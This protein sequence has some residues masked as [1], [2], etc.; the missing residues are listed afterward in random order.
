M[1][2]SDIV[3]D[4]LVESYENLDRLDRDL[5]GLEKN[6]QD[7]EALAG[8]FRTI[9]TIKGTCGF[10]GFN[11]LEKVAHVGENLL[12]RLR[13]GQLTLNPEITTALL[14]MVD[15]VRQMLK[16]IKSSGQDGD[17]DYPE[18]RETLTRLQTP[19]AAS[20][21]L[22][23]SSGPAPADSKVLASP[24]AP[25]PPLAKENLPAVPAPLPTEVA[26]PAEAGKKKEDSPRKPARGK[27]GGLLVER[28]QVQASDIARALEEQEH[29]DRRRLGEILV[30]LGLAKLEDVLAAQQTLEA[31]PRDSAPE[32]IRVGVNL[33]DKLMTLVG[34]LVLARNQLMQHTN[35]LEDT[36]LQAVSDR[37]N[38]IA[39]ELQGEVMKTRMQPIGNIWG[40]F[41]R[42]VRDVALGC[43]KE[44]NIEM[45]GKETELDKTII[46]A[47]KDPLTHLV[48]NSVDHGIELPE[49]RVKAGKDRAGRL[50][51]RAFHEGG[52]VIIEIS[53]DGAGLNPDR[54]RKK[55]VERAVITAEQA[56]RMTEREIFN[57]IFLPGFS[58]AEKV[59]NVSGRGVGMDVVKTN[60]EKI[61]GTVDVQST[62]GRGTTVRVKIPLTL[63][64]IP[65]LVVTCGGDR[66]AIPQ[67]NLLELVRIEADQAPTAVEMVH[68]APVYRLRGKLLPLVYLNRELRVEM[69]VQADDEQTDRAVATTDLD[70]S[71][72]RDKHREWINTLQQ[73][74][75]GK[76]SL[77]PQQAG[78]YEQCA[79]GKWIYSVGLKE[80]G[81][82]DD[83]V[84]LEK[85]HKHFHELVHKVL[86]LKSGGD[87]SMARQE[88]EAV[89]HTS[90]Q[91]MELTS[92]VEKRVLEFRNVSIVVLQ[93]DDRQF[94]LVVDEINDSE[95]IVVKPLRKQLKTVK[96][97]A[98]SS[99]MGDGKVALILDVLGL[100]QRANVVTETRDRNLTAKTTESAAGTVEKQTFLLF[101]GPGGSRMAI[102]LSALAR[103]EE[104]P[105]T[106]VEMSGSQWVTQYRGQILPLVRLNVVLE[107]RRSKLRA[108]QG[109]PAPDAGPIQ[110]LVLN[111]EERW[112]GLVV[113]EILDIVEDRAEVRSAATR[114]AV[115]YSVVINE[116]VTELLDIPAILQSLESN[117]A[118]ASTATSAVEV[119]SQAAA[120]TAQFCT[121]Y[122]DRLLFGVELKGVQEVIPSLGMT[123]VP[124]APGVVSG[125]INLRGQIV[126][127]VD[128]RRR[129]EL[130]P[131]PT[132]TLTT[133]VVVGSVDGAVSLLV[134]E[135]GDV[136]EVE[137]TTFEPPPETLRGS[138]RT[139]ITGVHKLDNRLMH[140]LDIEKACQMTDVSETV[141]ALR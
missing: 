45:E 83:M 130:Q 62:R 31:K 126:T 122:L 65:A 18:L 79:L 112:F 139:M 87:E 135:I 8:V 90:E 113:E 38:L 36:R 23:I 51:L 131:T 133:N 59:T 3:Q 85:A 110:V 67:V 132:G 124:L 81:A 34:E 61:G 16:E 9:H 60:V 20:D 13:D 102:P 32:T 35:T 84:A 118:Y 30:A 136:V 2:D 125:L 74:L 97:F 25:A 91:I 68:G 48:R 19:A 66:Y 55:A 47:I 10:L 69:N 128:L 95:E 29:G 129:L 109:P 58:T 33:L 22:A 116:R 138:V 37:M 115:L 56:A 108:L 27:I 82:I 40:Q 123:R 71:L 53:D 107:E 43:G 15:A 105:V 1:S 17:A 41:P 46:E 75:A 92:S 12:T 137:A 114:A 24:K 5:V 80:Y 52:Q 77:T 42:T 6:P 88:L 72:V 121:F 44:V 141:A 96:T 101:A 78:S 127:A 103:L 94:G 117:A 7:K 4:F 140:V 70:F 86:L 111:H 57:L 28:G 76:M 104:F 21:A 119:A 50:I 14:S 106:Q 73:V 98:G 64:I 100:A 26:P 63:A 39:T 49:D 93:A 11:K 134:D 99:I 54:I 120:Q 89:Q